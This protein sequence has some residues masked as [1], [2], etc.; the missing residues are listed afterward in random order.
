VFATS[1]TPDHFRRVLA[2]AGC[3]A[4]RPDANLAWRVFTEF[5]AIPVDCA[6]VALL[7]YAGTHSFTGRPRFELG[8]IHQFTHEEDGGYDGM[9]QRNASAPSTPSRL[10]NSRRSWSRS[11]HTT[12]T[13]VRRSSPTSKRC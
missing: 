4:D 13:R 9:E 7:S 1:E 11:G 10:R 5:A 8:F 12:A 3:D 2:L 6:D